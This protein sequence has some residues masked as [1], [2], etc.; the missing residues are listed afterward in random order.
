MRINSMLLRENIFCLMIALLNKNIIYLFYTFLRVVME[1]NALQ[2]LFF[3]GTRY[4][5]KVGRWGH[6]FQRGW[7]QGELCSSSTEA[8]PPR[9]QDYC[10][11]YGQVI[12]FDFS[13][14]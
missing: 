7:P 4:G 2:F 14:L 13:I 8:L 10:Y 3:A 12:I 9:Q 11:V 5:R 1:A 6:E